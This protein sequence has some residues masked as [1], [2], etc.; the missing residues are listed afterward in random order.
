MATKIINGIEHKQCTKCKIW[1]PCIEFPK[2]STHGESQC[3]T[4]CKCKECHRKNDK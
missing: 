2:D 3:F 4:H 1:K